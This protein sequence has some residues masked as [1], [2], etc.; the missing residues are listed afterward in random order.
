MGP[1]DAIAA[2]GFFGAVITA[3]IALGPVGRAFA[4]RLRSKDAGGSIAG[5]QDQLDEVI[6]RLDDVQRQLGEM[7]DRQDFTERMLAKARERG[8][9]EGP[10]R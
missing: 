6:G 4:D 3:I 1:G 2:A 9:L 5:L 7:A 8:L 10:A